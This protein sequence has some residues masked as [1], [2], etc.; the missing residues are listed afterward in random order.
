MG[1]VGYDSFCCAGWRCGCWHGSGMKRSLT[2]ML[3][4]MLGWPRFHHGSAHMACAAAHALFLHL[5]LLLCYADAYAMHGACTQQ[6]LG[7][8]SWRHLATSGWPCLSCFFSAR[9]QCC[10]S[11]LA[12]LVGWC[13]RLGCHQSDHNGCRA[14]LVSGAL[15]NFDVEMHVW[16][17]LSCGNHKTPSERRC[18]S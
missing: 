18:P 9:I 15:P 12:V 14:D 17:V 5:L 6:C 1:P 2:C 10:C 13:K 16:I 8:G 3:R 7:H 4:T 11:L